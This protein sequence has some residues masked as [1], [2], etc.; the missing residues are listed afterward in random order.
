MEEE[1]I[2]SKTKKVKKERS[3]KIDNIL[4]DI[5]LFICIVVLSIGICPKTMQN[6]TYYTIKCGEYIFQNGIFD[7][8]EDP[9]SWHDLSYTWPHWLYDLCMYIFYA[10]CGRFWEVRNIHINN[11]LNCYFRTSFI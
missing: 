9:F 8:N 10:M 11:L 4:F 5:I 6:D 3:E 7:I 2:K 1:L